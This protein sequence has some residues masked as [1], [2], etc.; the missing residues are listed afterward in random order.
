MTRHI[1]TMMIVAALLASAVSG[2][3]EQQY[4]YVP[5]AVAADEKASKSDGILVR[6][7]PIKK[8]DTLSHISQKFS[9]HS[10]YY[11]QIL[12]FNDIKNPNRIY[13]GDLLRVPVSRNRDALRPGKKTLKKRHS[14]AST[15]VVSQQRATGDQKKS[16]IAEESMGEVTPKPVAPLVKHARKTKPSPEASAA[17]SEQLLFERAIKAYRQDDYRAALELFDRFLVEYPSSAL[18]ADAT[19]YKA[20]CYLKQSNQ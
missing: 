4:L 5:Q 10:S 1:V 20:E 14:K 3:A 15:A 13:T 19:L 12:L 17:A 11:P 7:I 18:A 9:G 6:E 16:V 8:G 2:W